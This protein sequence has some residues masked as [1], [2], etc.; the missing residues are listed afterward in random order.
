MPFLMSA[1]G[2][3]MKRSPDAALTPAHFVTIDGIVKKQCDALDGAKDG[4]IQNPAACNFNPDRDLPRCKAG[5]SGGQ[6][7]S[8]AQVETVSVALNAVTDERGNVVQ[9]GFSVSELD[10]LVPEIVGLADPIHK[11]FVRGNDPAFKTASLFSFRRGAPGPATGYHAVV[12]ASDVALH[13][14][15]LASGS[16][17]VPEDMRRLKAAGTKLL[18]WHNWSDEKLTPYSSINWYKQFA[19]S[20]GGLAKAQQ[21]ARLFLLPGTSHCSITGIAPNSFDAIG[22]LER[23][24][25]HKA[26]PDTL[27]ANVAHRQFS[28]GAPRSPNMATPN[29]TMPLCK[30]PQQARYSG[31]GD[32]KDGANWTCAA[33]DKSL[34]KLGASGVA[35]GVVR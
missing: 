21:Q 35:A 5:E 31:K 13:R 1:V 34:L 15:A 2:V 14:A 19:G 18:I 25:E 24:V 28:P 33:G 8:A 32:I 11:V 30:F 10:G 22:A 4:L 23:W 12:K 29:W 26:A 7:F 9:P 3:A 27:M 20:V 16:R 17:G 6:C